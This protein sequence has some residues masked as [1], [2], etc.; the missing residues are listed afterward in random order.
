MWREQP[1][2]GPCTGFC[3]LTV[4]SLPQEDAPMVDMS[5]YDSTSEVMY[6]TRN[7]TYS[8]KGASDAPQHVLGF[9]NL[10]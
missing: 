5:E 7:D 4:P 2:T 8:L 6:E 1:D 10:S 9:G 3:P